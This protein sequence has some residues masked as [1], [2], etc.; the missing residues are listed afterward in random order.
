[1]D[2]L[3]AESTGELEDRLQ[4]SW[5]MLQDFTAQEARGL[6]ASLLSSRTYRD[7]LRDALLTV[8]KHPWPPANWIPGEDDAGTGI[9]LGIVASD[10]RL[11][12]RSLRD[13]CEALD[14]PFVQPE[15]RVSAA[16]A[17]PLIRGS[18]YIKYNSKTRQCY[19]TQYQGR[20]RGVLVSLG[21]VQIGHLP[22]G[23]HDESKSNPPP[24]IS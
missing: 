9:L 16:A 17:L 21:T 2:H 23:L 20:D 7:A 13:Y 1:M 3:H 18:V 10:I 19:A 8:V 6:G 11:A 24:S 15:S 4:Q 22:L 5:K 12:L 14:V